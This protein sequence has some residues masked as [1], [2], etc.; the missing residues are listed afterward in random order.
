MAFRFDPIAQNSDSP[1]WNGSIVGLMS[2]WVN[3]NDKREAAELVSRA[4]Y[5][6]SDVEG[7]DTPLSPWKELSLTTCAEDNS[8]DVPDGFV[9]IEDGEL[10]PT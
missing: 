4:L 10:Y 6:S 8:Q 9:L 7:W 2:C 1:H 5:G 3:A